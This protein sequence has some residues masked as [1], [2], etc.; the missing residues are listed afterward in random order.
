MDLG[1]SPCGC[2]IDIDIEDLLDFGNPVDACANDNPIDPEMTL[3]GNASMTKSSRT[4]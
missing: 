1:D 3:F 2:D 4:I